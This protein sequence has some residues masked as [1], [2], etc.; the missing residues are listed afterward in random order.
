MP[1]CIELISLKNELLHL[2]FLVTEEMKM[3]SHLEHMSPRPILIELPSSSQLL[4][5]VFC[6]H[7]VT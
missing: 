4:K 5:V 1:P 2:W 7:H 3:L 6:P